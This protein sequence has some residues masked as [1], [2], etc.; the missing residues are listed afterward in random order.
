MPRHL[1]GCFSLRKT[2][3]IFDEL[4]KIELETQTVSLRHTCLFRLDVYGLSLFSACT[5]R[6]CWYVYVSMVTFSTAKT[7]MLTFEVNFIVSKNKA[8]TIYY[9]CKMSQ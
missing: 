4:D 2:S 9:Q 8:L 6:I 7:Y 3:R 5:V 1:F